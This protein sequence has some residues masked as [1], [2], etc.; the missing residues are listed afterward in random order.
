MLR[1]RH[2]SLHGESPYTA[3]QEVSELLIQSSGD[4]HCY[5]F[6]V[7]RGVDPTSW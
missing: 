4:Y 6:F 5:L 2:W 3:R 7:D 1:H